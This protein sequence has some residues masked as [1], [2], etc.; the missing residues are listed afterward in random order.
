MEHRFWIIDEGL[1]PFVAGEF[2]PYGADLNHRDIGTIT[3]A[4][5]EARYPEALAA[6]RRRED[7]LSALSAE[8]LEA[9]EGPLI[10]PPS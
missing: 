3:E 7:Y 6:W 4:E 5:A 1:G 2:T 10:L 8:V 9:V